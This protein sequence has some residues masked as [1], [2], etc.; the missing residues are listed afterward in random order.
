MAP[1]TFASPALSSSVSPIKVRA[2]CPGLTKRYGCKLLV[3][4]EVYDL[5]TDA[6]RR[7]TSLECWPRKWKLA[8]I[9]THNP[10]WCDLADDLTM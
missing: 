6:I 1:S 10:Q 2:A 3:H 8:L 7:E 9:E 4:Y 5:I